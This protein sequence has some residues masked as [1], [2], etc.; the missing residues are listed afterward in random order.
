[1]KIRV[2]CSYCESERFVRYA[3]VVWKDGDWDVIV[4]VGKFCPLCYEEETHA[5]K[6]KEEPKDGES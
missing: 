5:S 1:M 6:L 3:D 4:S 2:F